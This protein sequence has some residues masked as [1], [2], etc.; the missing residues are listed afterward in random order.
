MSKNGDHIVAYQA[1]PALVIFAYVIT[2]TAD[3]GGNNVTSQMKLIY[4]I[5]SDTIRINY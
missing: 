5:K 1:H 4:M 2:L 3:V